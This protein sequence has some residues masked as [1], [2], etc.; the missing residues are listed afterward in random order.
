[1]S[2]PEGIAWLAGLPWLQ[3]ALIGL[4]VAARLAGRLRGAR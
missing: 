3:I 2:G 1:M 4:P